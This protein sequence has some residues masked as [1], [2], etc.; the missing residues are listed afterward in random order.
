M[1]IVA[2]SITCRVCKNEVPLLNYWGAKYHEPYFS[3]EGCGK[4]VEKPYNLVNPQSL[5]TG[6]YIPLLMETDEKHDRYD[7]CQTYEACCYDDTFM[8]G[9]Y[10]TLE[11]TSPVNLYQVDTFEEYSVFPVNEKNIRKVVTV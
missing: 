9:V 7:P 10:D 4:F 11:T 3:C 6:I 8:Y 5:L 2:H 1:N